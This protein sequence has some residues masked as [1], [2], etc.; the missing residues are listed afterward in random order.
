MLAGDGGN[1]D[2]DDGVPHGDCNA[3]EDGEDADGCNA[4]IV[5]KIDRRND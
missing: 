2:G 1:C 3:G 4:C 5:N